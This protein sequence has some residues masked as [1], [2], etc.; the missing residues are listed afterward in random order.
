MPENKK[1]F[2]IINK[3][4]GPGYQPEVEGKLISRCGELNMEC[5]IEF[6]QGRGHATELA[7]QAVRDGFKMVFAMGG[8]GT[9]NE[10]AKGLIHSPAIMGILPKG[11]GNGLARHLGIPLKFPA[12]LDVLSAEQHIEMD[13]IL[14]NEHLSVNVSGIGFDGHVAGLFGKNG[15]RGLIS[16]GKLVIQEFLRFKEFNIAL[17][18]DGQSIN[19]D[20]FIVA[21]ANSAQFGNNAKVSP[22]ASVRDQYIDVCFIKKVPFIKA[23]GFALKMF[24][25]TLNNS[26]FVEII[27]AQKI[28]I[29]FPNPM[30]F[31]VDGESMEATRNFA[32]KIQP[33]SLN[34]LVPAHVKGKL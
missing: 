10:V 24:N 9:V 32:I 3:Y 19:R 20:A 11:S 28:S 4:S 5:S 31:H 17:V 23:P 8:D 7:K 18:V 22:F 30:P 33:R 12:M 2:F 14:I 16:Y 29:Q 6:T 34:M 15:K 26:S 25:G 27:Q 21:L 13:T 1:V